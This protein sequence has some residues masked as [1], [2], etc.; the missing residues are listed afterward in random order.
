MKKNLVAHKA[1]EMAE[2]KTIGDFVDA[3]LDE[4]EE[5]G[6][7]LIKEYLKDI[8][9]SFLLS[10]PFF[11]FVEKGIGKVKELIMDLLQKALRRLEEGE[12]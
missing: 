9:P 3:V 6:E 10:L 12:K 4:L 7:E 5:E 11:N 2:D 8:L 1:Q